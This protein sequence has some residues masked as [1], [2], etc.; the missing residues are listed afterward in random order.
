MKNQKFP[1]ATQASLLALRAGK[2]IFML[3]I[4]GIIIVV[5]IILLIAT[6]KKKP[7]GPAPAAP[8]ATKPEEFTK[9]PTEEPKDTEQKPME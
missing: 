2:F 9:S 7:V 5:V 8:E 1:P 4:I 6:R 3:Y